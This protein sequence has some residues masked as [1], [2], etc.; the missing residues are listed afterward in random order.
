MVT[1]TKLASLKDAIRDVVRDGDSIVLGAALETDIPFAAAHELIRQGKR[2]LTVIA[3]ISD[4]GTD[5]LIGAGCVGG[6]RG[7]WV[8]NMMGGVGY[9]YRRA[10]EQQVP[11]A[12][13]VRDYTNLSLGL[14]LFAGASGVPYVPMRSLLG[15]DILK[16]NPDFRRDENP[17]S[18]EHE[19]VVL[20]PALVPDVA[21]LCVQRADTSGTCHHWGSRGVA[22]EAALAAKRVIVIADEIVDRAVIASDPSRVLAPGHIITAV[23]H[24]P[25]AQHPAPMTGRWKR[26]NAFFV[27]YLACSKTREGYL[28]WLKEWV[29]DVPDHTAYRAKL[30]AAM[31]ELRIKGET[32][33]AP[34]NYAPE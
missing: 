30:G 8:G 11:R 13:A 2:D 31:D 10:C 18:Q 17:F 27:N 7:A 5:L 24:V 20:V 15:S 6:I 34:V 9:N 28:A 23:C 12:I 29:L 19:P 33:A 22:Q 21:I 3:P 4:A 32:L 14:A 25:A 1:P 16:T 26:D